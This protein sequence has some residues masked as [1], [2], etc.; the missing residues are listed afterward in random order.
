MNHKLTKDDINRIAPIVRALPSG[1][2]ER[3]VTTARLYCSS[4]GMTEPDLADPVGGQAARRLAQTRGWLIFTPSTLDL[5]RGRYTIGQMLYLRIIRLNYLRAT[6]AGEALPEWAARAIELL[7]P[8]DPDT[9]RFRMTDD[10][11]TAERVIGR[12]GTS[13]DRTVDL[14]PT[15]KNDGWR[16]C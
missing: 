14:C 2:L 9:P 10:M 13:F 12:A 16:Q 6:K 5:R 7:E 8:L 15:C 11:I 1:Q 4:C 3:K